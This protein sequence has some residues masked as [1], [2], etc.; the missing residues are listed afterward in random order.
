MGVACAP[1]I[2][3][4]KMS[5]LMSTLEYVRAYIDDLLC[6]TKGDFEDHLTRLR[7]VLI[8]LQG[9]GLKVN[10]RKCFWGTDET[11]YLGYILSRE[12][13][14]PQPKKL[15]QSLQSN[16]LQRLKNYVDSWAWSSATEI[17]GRSAAKCLPHSLI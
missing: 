14:K 4:A 15:R 17:Y 11:E 2:F 12:G 10:A 9:A 13:I 16:R 7:E 1:D 8:R 5:E 6:I 3:Q